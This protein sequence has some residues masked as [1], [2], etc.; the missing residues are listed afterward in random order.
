MINEGNGKFTLR[1]LPVEAQF[2]P[3]FGIEIGDFNDDSNMDIL[4]G[5][6]M[7]KVKPQVGRYDASYGTLLIGDGKNNFKAM[8][9]K[10]SGIKLDGEVRDIVTIKNLNNSILLISRNNDSVLTYEKK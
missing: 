1:A 2:S 3:V 8:A 7:Y 5:G 10:S 4:L 9:A 6:N